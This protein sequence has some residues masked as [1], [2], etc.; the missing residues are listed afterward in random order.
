MPEK[1]FDNRL[2]YIPPEVW[3]KI[4]KIDELKGQW[5]GGV[6]FAPQVLGRLKKTVLITSA[7]ASTRIEGARFSDEDVEKLMRGLSIQKFSD[8]DK[9]EVRGY[10]ELL[11]KIFDSWKH[12]SFSENSIKH[13]HQ[14]MLRYVEKDKLHR[15]DYKK[16][17]N[18]V[19]MIDASG[20]SIGKLFDT[21]AAYLIP[22]EMQELVEWTKNALGEKKYHPLLLIGNFIVEFLAIHPFH[23]GN[24]RL[25]RILTNLL[26][27]KSGY[28]FMPYISHEKII[29]VNKPDY[30][31]ALRKSQKTFKTKSEDITDWLSFFSNVL[32]T[33]SSYAIGLF[34]KENIEK[35]LSPKQLAVWQYLQTVEEAAPE[36][37]SRNTLVARV[38]VSQSLNK[39]LQLNKVER[40]GMGRSTRYRRI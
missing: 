35:I 7:G 39:L 28:L 20:N 25:S 16:I 12:I 18:K 22:K 5:I 23:D 37:I 9:Q 11:E 40:I 24:G 29:E 3:A 4:T 6:N 13:L 31:M 8:R 26:L 2:K 17:E 27:L 1:S 21:T 14:E 38:T 15:G 19:E 30:Y 32:L 10:Y 36:E 34:T 33:Q